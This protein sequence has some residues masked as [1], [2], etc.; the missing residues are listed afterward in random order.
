MFNAR[1]K[2][3][4]LTSLH[5]PISLNRC[6]VDLLVRLQLLIIKGPITLYATESGIIPVEL[7]SM[8]GAV[9]A[10]SFLRAS[11]TKIEA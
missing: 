3:D 11:S 8:N 2:Q 9:L 10:K 1:E 6:F 7:A 5:S 4:I